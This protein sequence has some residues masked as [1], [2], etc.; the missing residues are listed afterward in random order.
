[1]EQSRIDEIAKRLLGKVPEAARNIQA[2]LEEN[3][4][5]VLRA[6]LSRLDLVSAM[7]SPCNRKC[8]RERARG[9]RRSKRGCRNWN[10]RSL[11]AVP[12]LYCWAM[13]TM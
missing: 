12:S 11:A 5:A 7:N 2:D 1:M 6:S 9:S 10:P 4:R 8:W 3:F 13:P